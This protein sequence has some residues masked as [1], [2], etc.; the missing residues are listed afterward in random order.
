MAV[1]TSEMIERRLREHAEIY[2]TLPHSFQLAQ[3][4][5]PGCE[6][7]YQRGWS[8]GYSSGRRRWKEVRE[9]EKADARLEDRR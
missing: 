8:A 1:L 7:S 6:D 2:G 3:Q 4:S 9:E 5:C